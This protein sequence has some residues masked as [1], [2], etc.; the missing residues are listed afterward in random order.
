MIPMPFQM[1]AAGV[2]ACLTRC[3]IPAALACTW[4]S[5]PL[6]MAFFIYIQ[7]KAGVLVLGHGDREPHG[8]IVDLLKHAPLPFI[9][10][11][12]VVGIVS[13]IVIYP[14]ALYGW[15]WVTA[16]FLQP[17]PRKAKALAPEKVMSDSQV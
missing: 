4:I 15:D 6:T 13:A 8:G 1:A 12:V 11:S 10:G 14:I 3:N 2:I 17:L 5:N 7:Y 16:R 9:T